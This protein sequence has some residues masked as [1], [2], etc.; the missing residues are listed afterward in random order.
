M[1]YTHATINHI[2]WRAPTGPANQSCQEQSLRA[3]LIQSGRKMAAK[4]IN[5][6][7]VTCRQNHGEKC[8]KS[9]IWRWLN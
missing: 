7:L 8:R 5:G 9:R 6:S 2:E 3:H 4:V 1:A